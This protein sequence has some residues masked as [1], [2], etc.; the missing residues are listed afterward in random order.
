M[1]ASACQIDSR[2]GPLSVIQWQDTIVA[3]GYQE[4]ATL[5][6]RAQSRYPELSVKKEKNITVGKIVGRY[7]D[8]ELDAFDDL[9][10][11]QPGGLFMQS[12]WQA[13]RAIPAGSVATYAELAM[14]AGSP[15]AVRAAG[16]ACSSNLV[17][18]FVPCHRVIRSDGALGNYGFGIDLKQR[19]LA[20]EGLSAPSRK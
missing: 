15:R 1:R 11:Q 13:M 14:R 20:H 9:N 19:L 2:F 17:A 10:V 12:A 7:D 16:T 18:P 5:L 6:A 8:G 4:L 3:A